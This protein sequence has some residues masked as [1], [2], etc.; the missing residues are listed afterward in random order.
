VN[1]HLFSKHKTDTKNQRTV[2]TKTIIDAY[3]ITL[4]CPDHEEILELKEQFKPSNH[5]YKVWDTSWLLIDYLKQFVNLK[6]KTILDIGCGWGLSAIFCAKH[7]KAPVTCV[8]IDNDVYPY[9]NLMAETNKV[10]V[11]FLNLDIDRIDMSILNKAD[12]IIGS[13]IC[14]CHELIDPLRRLFKNAE[15][16]SVNQ[17][18]IADPGR[19]PFDDL[20]E[21]YMRNKNIEIIEW[22]IHTPIPFAGKILKI[23]W[24]GE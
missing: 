18:I 16:S 6:G 19:W 20:T 9:L 2:K 7:F 10:K 24:I 15:T 8:D 4:L 12:I 21:F 23:E 22:S 17:I 13:D 5:G 11:N 1:Y 14:F 3:G